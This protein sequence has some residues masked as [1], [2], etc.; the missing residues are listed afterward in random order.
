MTSHVSELEVLT[1]VHITILPKT[2]YRFIIL[3]KIQKFFFYGNESD[4][5]IYK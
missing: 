4:S 2:I 5:Q 1:T 3:I